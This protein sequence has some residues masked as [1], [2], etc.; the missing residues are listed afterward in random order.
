MGI[1]SQ[2]IELLPYLATVLVLILSSLK[3]FKVHFRKKA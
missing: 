1:A 2:I 3:Q